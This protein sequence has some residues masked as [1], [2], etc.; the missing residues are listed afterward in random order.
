VNGK[1]RGLM[2]LNDI[3]KMSLPRIADI[4]A[5]KFSDAKKG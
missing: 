2:G 3:E 4:V 5:E 1:R